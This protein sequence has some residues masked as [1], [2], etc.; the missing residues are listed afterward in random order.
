DMNRWQPVQLAVFIDQSGNILPNGAPPF[1]SAEWGNV[2][3]FAMNP[4]QSEL[5]TRDGHN[6]RVYHRPPP[7]ALIDTSISSEATRQYQWN[8]A[9]VAVWSSLLDPKDSVFIDISPASLG[10]NDVSDYPADLS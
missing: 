7:P 9:L 3:P 10:N 8:H 5:L 2:A 1:Q 4:D 6:Y